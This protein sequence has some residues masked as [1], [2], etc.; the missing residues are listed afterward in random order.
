MKKRIICA[1]LVLALA[2]GAYGCSAAK[3]MAATEYDA[4]TKTA[5][6]D[7]GEPVVNGGDYGYA[8][9]AEAG[10]IPEAAYA[11]DAGEGAADVARSVTGE[12]KATYDETIEKQLPEAGQLT[13][14]VWSDN[15]NW[16][17]FSNLVT[18]GTISFP[19]FGIDPTRRVMITVKDK[20]GSPV[21]NAK[22]NLLDKDNNVI[23]S[24][25][26]D[27]NGIVYL[28]AQ[29]ND[30]GVA[31]EI[32]SGGKKQTYE[33]SVPKNDG[34]S[35]NKAVGVE[36]DVVFDG[37][38]KLYP[39]MDIMFIVDTT[40]SMSDEMLFLQSEFTEITKAV[41]N[42]KTRYS[43]NFYRDEGDDYVTKCSGFTDDVKDIQNK[44]NNEDAN[45]GGDFPEAV[46]EALSETMFAKDWG[47]ESVKLAFLIFDAPPHDDKEKE[48]LEATKQASEKGIRL[49]PVVA[50]DNDRDTELFGRAIA[51]VTGGTYV[52][53]T[54]DSGIG[55]SH[56][57]PIIGSYEVKSLY[58]TIIEV[59]NQYRQA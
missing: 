7:D 1:A 44:L 11:D 2:I 57:E 4:M 39:A 6:I 38:G 15:E 56:E 51:A 40:G 42:D 25:V 30:E 21:P 17:F 19:S 45:G 8:G 26:S 29:N 47:D 48:L 14:G 22:A 24:G 58:D 35:K 54:D 20:S 3:D 55:N 13:A 27:K 32:E 10:A 16:G 9:D 41:G 5:G 53:L 28:F 46:A 12:S 43:V 52:F 59:I 23:W 31:V 50:S 34:Q 37:S 49:I 33:L 36:M 18:S